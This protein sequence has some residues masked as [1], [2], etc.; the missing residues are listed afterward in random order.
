MAPASKLGRGKPLKNQTKEV[1]QKIYRYFE[2]EIERDPNSTVSATQLV[3]HATGISTYALRRVLTEHKPVI[4]KTN[5]KTLK[6]RCKKNIA[7]DDYN[8]QA[9]RR[10]IHGFYTKDEEFPIMKDLYLILKADLDYQGSLFTLRRHVA[11]LGFKWAEKADNNSIL[12]EKHDVRLS[13]LHYLTGIEAHR[14]QG[15]D[16]VYTGEIVIACSRIST[17]PKPDGTSTILKQPAKSKS[18]ILLAGD[19]KGILNNTIYVCDGNKKEFKDE[20]DCKRDNYEQYEKWLKYVLLPN[21]KPSSVVVID[22]GTPCHNRLSNPIPHS[23]SRRKEMLDYLT[24]RNVPY[25]SDMYKPQLYQ[26]IVLCKDKSN[27][28]R[29]EVFLREHGHTVIRLPQQHPDLSPIKAVLASIRGYIGNKSTVS[30][31]VDTILKIAK[32][33]VF[34]ITPEEWE[35]ACRLAEAEENN[36]KAMEKIIDDISERTFTNVDNESND[37]DVDDENSDQESID[38]D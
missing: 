9:I 30:L 23:N 1:I 38:S 21:L 31:P 25:S 4:M 35:H 13:R 19:K 36:L 33:K 29:T 32:E 26:L 8:A 15:R 3:T 18:V 7:F 14:V 12:I 27:D 5:I 2:T 24:A 16:I 22:G 37:S 10:I 20:L 28:Y 34:S 6:K 11:K 17:K